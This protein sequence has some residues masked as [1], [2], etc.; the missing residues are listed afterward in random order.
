[1]C[2]RQNCYNKDALGLEWILLPHLMLS[3]MRY[4]KY[5]ESILFVK[6]YFIAYRIQCQMKFVYI[7]VREDQDVISCM[8][9]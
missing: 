1:M 8:N 9:K 4:F 6:L 2:H 5:L 3:V 7:Q